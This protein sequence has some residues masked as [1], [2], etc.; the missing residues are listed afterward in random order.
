VRTRPYLVTA[1]ALL[2]VYLVA[3]VVLLA[4]EDFDHRGPL[5][6][7]RSGADLV[8]G[9][10]GLAVI[11]GLGWIYG[12]LGRRAGP[13]GR[14]RWWSQPWVLLVLALVPV[15]GWT[16]LA[17][18]P[19]VE[20]RPK[21]RAAVG[22]VFVFTGLVLFRLLTDAARTGD[23]WALA[24][25]GLLAAGLLT[26]LGASRTLRPAVTAAPV[27]AEEPAAFAVQGPADR[28]T[29]ADAG[30]M[31]V[32]DDGLT[33]AITAGAGESASVAGF[34]ASTGWGQVGGLTD[35]T[36]VEGWTWDTLV[37]PARTKAELQ[38]VV[39]MVKEPDLVRTAEVE[40][41]AGLLLTGPPGSGKTT[42][43]KVLAAQTGCTFHPMTGGDVT[44]QRLS[45]PAGA[46]AR[47]FDRACQNQPSIVFLDEID[48][49][50][51]TRGDSDGDDRRLNQ[52]LAELD[53][54]GGR[55]GVFVLAATNRPD[56][57]DPALL[58]A[59]RLS[60]T[61]DIPLPDFRGRVALL[62][63]F[64]RR[65]ALDRVD[66]DLL[67]RRTAGLS[68]ADLE[69]LC[70]RAAEEALTRSSAV[71]AATD[72]EAALGKRGSG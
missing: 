24:V 45:D 41:A 6:Q 2:G 33:P 3:A 53:G 14:R 28:P 58:R 43:A 47:L 27:G 36:A 55:L 5:S 50:A 66:V 13:S 19:A 7:T 72:I 26:A 12:R 35:R 52:L 22:A 1:V 46:I 9:A 16:V 42:V 40:P 69:G 62:Q 49:I 32:V 59:G 57:L 39:A 18:L 67:A 34:N 37:L 17:A 20:R 64:T 11:L 68:G 29:S 48:A 61:I 21:A 70:Q 38:Q 71:V 56:Q 25:G 4:T 23:R 44:T 31:V 54:V 60:R 63:L 15:L 65:M 30:G 10:V 8:L 51:G